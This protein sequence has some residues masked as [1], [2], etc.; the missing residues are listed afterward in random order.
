MALAHP[1]ESLTG[2]SPETTDA[3]FIAQHQS[4]YAF[5]KPLAIGRR[6]LEIGFGD[7]Y[8]S[9]E[10]AGVAEEVVGIDI[11]SANIP[12][13][14]HKYPRPN[15]RFEQMDA[16]ALTFPAESFDL[17]CS[18]QVIEHIPEPLLPVFLRE[19]FRVLR[20]GG[21]YC[22]STLNLAH[23]MK[24]GQPYQKLSCH[25]KEFTASELEK[26]LQQTFPEVEM[27]GLYLTSGHRVAQRLKR[28]GL[29]RWGAASWNPVARFY[30]RMSVDDF[31]VGPIAP[32]ALDLY[33]L[34]RKSSSC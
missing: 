26:L 16:T 25:E 20:P 34:C 1:H 33:A 24:P 12:H 27:R 11:T 2:I 14:T 5:A 29:D 32:H 17:V 19:I 18:F 6:V 30:E 8:G 7:G 9:N 15:L 21:I 28:W 31:V 10:L 3:R 4:A 13:A 22:L 23:N